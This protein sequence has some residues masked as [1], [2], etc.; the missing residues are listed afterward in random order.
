M[1]N[2]TRRRFLSFAA[3]GAA[4]AAP[5][6]AWAAPRGGGVPTRLLDRARATL[7]RE[8]AGITHRD[9]IGIVDFSRP[10]R[11]AR[12]HLIDM[13]GGSASTYLVAHGRGSDP[14][15]RGWV[16]SFSN[17][18]GSY[19][20]SE[21][22]YLTGDTYEGKHGHSMRLAGLDPQNS[23]AA[24]R[25]IVVHAAWYVGPDIVRAHGKLGRSQGCFALAEHDLPAVLDRL[26]AGRLIFAGKA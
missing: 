17:T 15:H 25:A 5:G 19:A 21:G 24:P 26:G 11:D 22:A 1:Q 12:F 18:P 23:N 20:T 14:A 9:R 13:E 3:C 8:G 10:S 7:D 2:P 16:E 6:R 4:L